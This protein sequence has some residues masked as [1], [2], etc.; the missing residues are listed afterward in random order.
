MK[1]GMTGNMVESVSP[2]R[3]CSLSDICRYKDAI[4][5]NFN[6][7]IF[8]VSISCKVAKGIKDSLKEP[9]VTISDFMKESGY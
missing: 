7:D 2:C 1:K 3:N 6:S 9:N 8:K 5:I 4:Q